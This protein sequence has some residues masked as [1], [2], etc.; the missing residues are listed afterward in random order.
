M[1]LCGLPSSPAAM[2]AAAGM[3]HSTTFTAATTKVM[4]IASPVKAAA[5]KKH[6][7]FR[8]HHATAIAFAHDPD[9]SGHS[10][11]QRDTQSNLYQ[12]QPTLRLLHTDIPFAKFCLIFIGQ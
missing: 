6:I 11:Q 2:A 8:H 12:I 10:R 3:G 9:T 7:R 1:K 4:R 5:E